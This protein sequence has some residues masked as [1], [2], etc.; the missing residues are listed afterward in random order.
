MSASHAALGMRTVQP[1]T[2]PIWPKIKK[3]KTNSP[4]EEIHSFPRTLEPLSNREKKMPLLRSTTEK[5]Y[6]CKVDHPQSYWHF[7]LFGSLALAVDTPVIG[8]AI[9]SIPQQNSNKPALK[10]PAEM[11]YSLS[12][13][14]NARQHSKN[15]RDCWSQETAWLP[16]GAHHFLSIGYRKNLTVLLIQSNKHRRQSDAT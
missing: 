9:W 1:F 16:F 5:W 12:Q 15:K 6:Y 7:S 10:Q 14:E 11:K 4:E 13:I 8:G 2:L 3:T